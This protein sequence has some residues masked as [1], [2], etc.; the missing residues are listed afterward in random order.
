MRRPHL[1]L[2]RRARRIVNRLGPQRFVFVY[3]RVATPAHDPWALAVSPENFE[4]QLAVLSRFGRILTLSEL[5][6]HLDREPGA[7]R[8]AAI[9]FDDGYADNLLAARPALDRHDARATFYLSARLLDGR[10]P[11]WWDE[12]A[13]AVLAPVTLPDRLELSVGGAGIVADLGGDGGPS[14]AGWRS[15]YRPLTPRQDLYV[16]LWDALR[17]TPP[18]EQESVIAALLDWAGIPPGNDPADRPTTGEEAARLG[19]REGIEIGAHTLTHRSLPGADHATLNEE[20]GGSR[21]ACEEIAGRPVV[22]F[23][24]PYGDQDPVVRRAVAAAG[25]ESATTTVPGRIGPGM[26]RTALPRVH[27]DDWSGEELERRLA[28]GDLY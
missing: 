28:T 21:R 17:R 5:L 7:T 19:D 22:A 10:T 6:A 9:T 2:R 1:G 16:R 11:F 24:Y 23:S 25:F 27:M 12:L 3:H 13:R 15:W 26:D 8:V 20:I 18:A 4:E 14:P